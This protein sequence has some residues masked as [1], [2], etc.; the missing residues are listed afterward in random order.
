[1]RVIQADGWELGGDDAFPCVIAPT[2]IIHSCEVISRP[3][4]D[5]SGSA[6]VF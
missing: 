6:A 3:A 1:M 5:T 2:A 4:T